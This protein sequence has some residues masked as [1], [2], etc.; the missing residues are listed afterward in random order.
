MSTPG[1]IDFGSLMS[2]MMRAM[3][4]NTEPNLPDNFNK[5]MSDMSKTLSQQL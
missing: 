1:E 4:G 5:V 2:S 3:D